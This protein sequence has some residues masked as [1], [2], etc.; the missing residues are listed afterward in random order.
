MSGI[1]IAL[2]LLLVLGAYHG[3]KAG[4]LLELFSLVAVIIGILGGFKLMGLVM[5]LLAN[6]FEVDEK[7]L[8]YVAFGV[9]F[10]LIVVAVNLLGKLVK[11]SI[12]KSFLGG[13]DSA[14]GA[15]VGFLKT[16]FM[17]SIVLWIV[18]S[19]KFKLLS[20]WTEGSWL[21][22]SVAGFAPKLTEWISG[23]LPIFKDVF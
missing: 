20:Q 3:Y 12:D 14:F 8:P 13:F 22:P 2:S 9:V 10:L 16:T 7:V 1:D 5:V 21:Y 4:F 11:A 15:L 17:L 23:L 6:K 19:L 18:D